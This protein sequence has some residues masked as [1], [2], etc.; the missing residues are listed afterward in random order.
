M[1][2]FMPDIVAN[3]RLRVRLCSDI[4]SGKLAHAYIIE[5]AIGSGRHTLALNIAKAVA[6]ENRDS[7]D[8]PLPCGVCS[9]CRKIS[10]GICPDVITVKREEDKATIGVES[11]RFIRTDVWAVPNDLDVKFYIIEDADRLTAQ[12]QN[13]LLLTLE[14]P[15]S[16]AVFLLLCERAELLL[17]TVRSRA[18]TIRT[19]PVSRENMSAHLLSSA[20]DPVLNAARQLKQF[21]AQEFD[22][23][24]TASVG[25]IGRAYELLDPRL[26]SAV[27]E[28]RAK[29]RNFVDC[30]IDS[31][32]HSALLDAFSAFP[33][34]RDELIEYLD[35]VTLA[36]RD[37][38]VLKKSDNAELCF[39]SDREYVFDLSQ[40]RSASKLLGFI[41]ACNR[42]IEAL[43]KNANVKLTVTTL[44]ASLG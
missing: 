32:E 2:S 23:I 18:P 25:C 22:E 5:G 8:H 38:I 40:K 41:E 33:Q 20:P 29:V 4:T 19:E 39:Y 3:E 14:D 13:A 43:N 1:K 17:E 24:L 21:S 37:L 35:N 34:K 27:L 16:F 12:A 11:A 10:D 36:L 44:V 9:A 30:L 26:R 15:P 42:A 6:C 31:S 28:S 7:D